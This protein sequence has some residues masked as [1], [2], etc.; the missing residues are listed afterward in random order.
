[1]PYIDS[2]KRSLLD[3]HIDKLINKL[4]DVDGADYG[5]TE[6]I[7]FKILCKLADAK[8]KFTNL[9]SLIGVLETTK[10]IF[11]D[12][13]LKPYEDKKL[14]DSWLQSDIKE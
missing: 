3:E 2:Y 5:A 4:Q 11:A 6:Y 8:M 10:L 12:K 13:Y 7:F 1:M 9:N 14:H